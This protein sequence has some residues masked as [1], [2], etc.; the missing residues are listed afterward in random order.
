MEPRDGDVANWATCVGRQGIASGHP[1]LAAF[2][3]HISLLTRPCSLPNLPLKRIG[4]HP[5]LPT[6]VTTGPRCVFSATYLVFMLCHRAELG[7]Q[8]QLE[9]NVAEEP[10]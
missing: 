8:L 1:L 7:L 6:A 3:T 10:W 5:L 2:C 4:P 9:L